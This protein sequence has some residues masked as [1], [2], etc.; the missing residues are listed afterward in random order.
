MPS[1][2]RTVLILLLA[3]SVAVPAEAA[4]RTHPKRRPAPHRRHKPKPKPKPPPAP[5]LKVLT[6]SAVNVT[7]TSA[8]LTAR[9]RGAQRRT[10]RYWFQ[11]GSSGAYGATTAKLRVPRTGV[12]N[13]SAGVPGVS[14][15]A[16]YHFRVVASNCGGCAAHT[17]YGQD[18]TFTTTGYLNP[19]Y[20]NSEA[21]DPYV[22]DN[23]GTHNDYW[24]FNTGNR[25]P[26]RHST[27]LIHWTDVSWALTSLPSW[28][29]QVGDWHPWAP[30]VVHAR[31]ACPGTGSADCYVM[32]YVGLS[33]QFGANCVAVATSATPQG[34]YT[35]QG[36]LSNGLVDTAGRPVG[37]GD[38]NGYGVIDPSPFVDPATGQAYLYVS[39]DF[40]CPPLSIFCTNGNS[41]LQPTVSV[42][43]LSADFMH[44]NGPRTPLFSADP[45]TWE[46]AGVV[47]PTV[48]GPFVVFHGG[49]YYLFYSGGSWRTTY[50]MGYATGSSPTG[51]FTKAP[52]NPF[53]APTASVLS[54]GGG[55]A[56][57]A[58]PHGGS[59]LLYH[60]RSGMLTS[61]RTM[62]IEP[63]GWAP[64]P[65]GPEAPQFMGPTSVPQPGQP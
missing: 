21:A 65:D 20:G 15:V 42:I 62:R 55:D 22:L 60:G 11:Y 59:W 30:S 26:I 8:T 18:N 43:P 47:A 12:V 57:V 4:A 3:L 41:A 14:P 10:T 29:V 45:G 17:V 51:P 33:A 27:D 38:E 50:G 5:P 49:L 31:G 46:A 44:A 6:G 36:P 7:S 13:V 23:G 28:V 19:V 54:P 32:Y 2:V 16:S 1:H 39:E 56:F 9:L 40:A 58:G 37:C 52:T 24:A 53:M 61:P 63:F 48:E 64:T 25:F 35:D 34:P